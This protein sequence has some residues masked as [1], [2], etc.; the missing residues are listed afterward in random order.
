MGEAAA[1]ENA[2]QI[3][4]EILEAPIFVYNFQVEDYHT[5]YVT[6]SGVLV[7]NS[8][9]T[10]KHHML[11]N[12]N[13]SYTPKFREITDKYNLNLNKEWNIFEVEKHLGRHTSA[14]HEFMLARLK[15]IDLKA[16]G[17]INVFMRDFNRLANYVMNNPEILY[18]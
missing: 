6:D 10:Q 18:R 7:H 5:Y 15:V 9:G 11:T 2:E 16:N 12:K 8:C 1:N 17:D 3:Q 14:Y 4:H 13:K